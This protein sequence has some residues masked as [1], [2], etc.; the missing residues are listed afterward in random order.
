[1]KLYK[2]LLIACLAAVLMIL[3][4]QALC[5][6]GILVII[7]PPHNPS[8]EIEIPAN[9][10]IPLNASSKPPPEAF[11]SLE[12]KALSYIRSNVRITVDGE[13]YHVGEVVEITFI[14]EGNS[15]VELSNPPWAVFKLTKDGWVKVCLLYTS[16]SP[17]DLSTSRMPS[18]A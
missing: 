8:I 9:A 13:E 5:G 6:G 7:L 1:M 2:S 4:S 11:E 3:L 16:P 12:E 14:N 15:T 10:S 18:S 17:R